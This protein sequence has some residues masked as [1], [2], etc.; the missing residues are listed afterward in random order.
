MRRF[1]LVLVLGAVGIF[2]L[3]FYQRWF[4]VV[5]DQADGKSNVTLSVD[6]DKF[7]ED[8]KTAQEKVQDLGSKIK[9]K[10]AGPNEK[11]MDGKLVSVTADRL[12]MINLEGKEH[13]H[14]LATSV[15]VT[16]DGKT[17]TTADLKAGM[18]IRVTTNALAP[19]AASHIEALDNNPDF[20]KGA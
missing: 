14:A 16:C 9:N 4:L 13:G 10:A 2:A 12:T 3:G 19:H 17:C 1:Y 7:E 6:T 20:A 18:R 11:S 8:R 5:S 15:I